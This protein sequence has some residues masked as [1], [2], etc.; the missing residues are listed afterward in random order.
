MLEQAS[1]NGDDVA[2]KYALL[3]EARKLGVDVGSVEL[4]ESAVG[5]TAMAFE[6]D[7]AKLVAES[8]EDTVAKTRLPAVNKAIVQALL[9]RLGTAM[10]AEEFNLA[11]RLGKLALDTVRK[12]R[13]AELTKQVVELNRELA[14]VKGDWDKLQTALTTLTDKPEDPAANLAVGRYLCFTKGDWDA[15]LPLLAKSGD[16]MLRALAKQSVPAP[17]DAPAQMAL[18]D[19]WFAA[20]EAA[21][22]KAKPDFE[23]GAARYYRLALP[24]LTGLVK[25]KVEQ[26]L[27]QLPAPA[28]EPKDEHPLG[29]R[30]KIE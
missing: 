15:G 4:I 10:K 1:Q 12:S 20:A 19:A 3:S 6:V 16:G 30:L 5:A 25:V 14:T 24:N 18:G 22:K 11:A 7:L 8:Y 2:V 23:A 17:A 21:T 26:R 29:P 13:D 27:K 9:P 28:N